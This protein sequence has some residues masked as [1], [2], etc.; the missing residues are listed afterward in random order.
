MKKQ[1]KNLKALSEQD[2]ANKMLEFKKELMKERAQASAGA[3]TKNPGK[4]RSIK[5][6]IARIHTLANQKEA[7]KK[8]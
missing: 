7:N 6:N 4:I 1:M 8:I 3:S 2:R 5:R